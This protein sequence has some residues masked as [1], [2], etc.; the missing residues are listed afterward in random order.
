[1]KLEGFYKFAKIGKIDGELTQFGAP[2]PHTTSI[3]FDY[4]SFFITLGFGM[5]L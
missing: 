4:S 2:V 1:M 5:E 3:D